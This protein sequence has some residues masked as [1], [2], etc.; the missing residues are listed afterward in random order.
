MTSTRRA[1]CW[2]LAVALLCTVAVIAS[3]DPEPVRDVTITTAPEAIPIPY[4]G[5]TP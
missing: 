5:D 3:G 1:L 4:E 2:A